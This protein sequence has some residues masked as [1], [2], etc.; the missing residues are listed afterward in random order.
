[1]KPTRLLPFLFVFFIIACGGEENAATQG[2]NSDIR[3]FSGAE[4]KASLT[5]AF[6]KPFA[7][8]DIPLRFDDIAALVAKDL[9]LSWNGNFGRMEVQVKDEFTFHIQADE[10]DTEAYKRELQQDGVFDYVFFE[11]SDEGLLYQVKLPT[12][13]IVGHHY[14]RSLQANTERYLVCTDPELELSQFEAREAAT[15]MN[16]LRVVE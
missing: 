4:E 14:A 9:K 11:E 3:A 6:E 13:K 10:R 2:D 8:H 7:D 1:M 5:E 12:G 16:S 15:V